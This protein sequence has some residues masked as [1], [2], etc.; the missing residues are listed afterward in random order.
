MEHSW[1]VF[2]LGPTEAALP[3]AAFKITRERIDLAAQAAQPAL[4][5]IVPAVLGTVGLHSLLRGEVAQL[6]NWSEEDEE[7]KAGAGS[8]PVTEETE[9][10]Q[11][12]DEAKQLAAQELKESRKRR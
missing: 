8:K 6:W 1:D 2:L 11:I 4:L 3:R 10:Q 9:L 12:E 5:Y 7:E